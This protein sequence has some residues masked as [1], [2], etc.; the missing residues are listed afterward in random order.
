MAGDLAYLQARAD[1]FQLPDLQPVEQR[2][3]F[4][5]TGWKVMGGELLAT[6]RWRESGQGGVISEKGSF[7][8]HHTPR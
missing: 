4:R 2:G 5:T 6:K 3:P 7:A 1:P 8:L